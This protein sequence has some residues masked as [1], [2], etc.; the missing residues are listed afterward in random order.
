[1]SPVPNAYGVSI[2]PSPYSLVQAQAEM[3]GAGTTTTPG[4][5][6]K[7]CKSTFGPIASP[8]HHNIA[9]QALGLPVDPWTRGPVDPWTRGPVDPWT[10]GPVDP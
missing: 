3:Q 1:M 2:R 6:P 7:T 9:G 4:H 5:C 10:R 8:D